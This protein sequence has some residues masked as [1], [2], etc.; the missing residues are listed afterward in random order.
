MPKQNYFKRPRKMNPNSLANLILWKPGQSGN[1]TGKRKHDVT[2]D[3]CREFFERNQAGVYK[4]MGT[5]VLEG[6]V[7]AF[8]AMAERG[9]GKI[10][11]KVIL[12]GKLQLDGAGRLEALLARA[13]AEAG[14]EAES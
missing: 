2:Q 10:S 1:P 13:V 5:K 3:I 8:E 6:N 12:D 9:Y 11:E 14:G 4:A 7:Q